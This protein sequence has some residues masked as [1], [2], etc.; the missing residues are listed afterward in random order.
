ML[1]I[2]RTSITP[3]CWRKSALKISGPG[4]TTRGLQPAEEAEDESP[5]PWPSYSLPLLDLPNTALTEPGSATNEPSKYGIYKGLDVAFGP[6]NTA[7]YIQ[8]VSAWA[9]A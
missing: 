7:V 6:D 2:S 8:F 3:A 4:A 1:P 5:D 9:R